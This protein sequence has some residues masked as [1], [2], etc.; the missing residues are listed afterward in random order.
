MHVSQVSGV[1]T[2]AN[3]AGASIAVSTHSYF[4]V[5]SSLKWRLHAFDNPPTASED[6][7][8]TSIRNQL[9]HIPFHTGMQGAGIRVRI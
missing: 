4:R 9:Y 3:V 8:S 2:V 6:S 1:G 5:V 7:A